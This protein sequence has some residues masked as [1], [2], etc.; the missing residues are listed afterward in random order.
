MKPICFSINW[1][2]IQ[3]KIGG[4]GDLLLHLRSNRSKKHD[5]VARREGIVDAISACYLSNVAVNAIR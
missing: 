4:S 1:S 2:D 3:S 5:N